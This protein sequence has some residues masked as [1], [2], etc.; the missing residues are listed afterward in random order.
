VFGLC[1]VTV[2]IVFAICFADTLKPFVL[3]V[4]PVACIVFGI[5]LILLTLFIT[6]KAYHMFFALLVLCFGLAGIID[7]VSMETFKM[8]EWWPFFGIVA[9]LSLF[10]TG[11][12]KYKHFNYG[13]SV[14]AI[15]LFVLGLLFMLF[16]FKIVK[17]SF[18]KMVVISG[19]VV[20]LLSVLS[21]VTIYY[22]QKKHK[23]L[24]IQNEEPE[25]FADE[26]LVSVD[27]EN[28]DD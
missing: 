25:I 8:K 12:Y 2:F 22:F 3:Y 1:L 16:S 7:L 5:T 9:G 4:F 27:L 24:S 28:Q 21:A 19:P 11:L 17:V 13:Y 23:E 14:P 10:V 20:V 6:K 18:R 26:D 15:F